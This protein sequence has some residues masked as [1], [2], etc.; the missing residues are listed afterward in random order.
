M[1]TQER[2]DDIG[3]HGYGSEKQDSNI[4][5]AKQAQEVDDEREDTAPSDSRQDTDTV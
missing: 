3:E 2:S 5:E 1:S 4:D